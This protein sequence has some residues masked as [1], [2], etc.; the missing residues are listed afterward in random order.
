MQAIYSIWF[1][2]KKKAASF[3]DPNREE[4]TW[5]KNY[6]Q[7]KTFFN[8]FQMDMLRDLLLYAVRVLPHLYNFFTI[9][10]KE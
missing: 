5:Q 9:F 8:H 7:K 10:W 6:A 3:N 4:S 1:K 2:V